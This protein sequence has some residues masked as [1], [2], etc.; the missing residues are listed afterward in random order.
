MSQRRMVMKGKTKGMR[1][2]V[3]LNGN[4]SKKGGE[5]VFY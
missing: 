3:E 5:M 1:H 2:L 4:G